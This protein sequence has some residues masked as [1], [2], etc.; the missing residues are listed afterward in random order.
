M[1]ST[2]VFRAVSTINII[3]TNTPPHAALSV[4]LFRRGHRH[5]WGYGGCGASGAGKRTV[6]GVHRIRIRSTQT[7]RREDTVFVLFFVGGCLFF[8]FWGDCMAHYPPPGFY[9]TS[10]IGRDA[11][12]G[13]AFLGLSSASWIIAA[14]LNLAA[15]RG[16]CDA[17]V[18]DSDS[19]SG[20]AARLFLQQ[21]ILCQ[22]I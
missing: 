16:D 2:C 1:A 21:G 8:V 5:T 18:W 4:L 6:P 7:V 10:C 15:F 20:L 11:W 3:D 12:P 19:F 9:H 14:G 13:F 17:T 22:Y